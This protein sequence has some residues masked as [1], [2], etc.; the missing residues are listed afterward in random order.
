MQTSTPARDRTS[1]NHFPDREKFLK[2]QSNQTVR[3]LKHVE[4]NRW[5]IFP[6]NDIVTEIKKEHP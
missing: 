1:K 5:S 4:R 2:P 3:F 6:I